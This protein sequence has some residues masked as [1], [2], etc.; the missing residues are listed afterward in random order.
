MRRSE[1]EQQRFE[2]IE[3]LEKVPISAAKQNPLYRKAKLLLTNKWMR[4]PAIHR[5]GLL[6]AA[7][8]LISIA[9]NNPF[10]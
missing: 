9:D 2:L 6:K 3:H 10:S 4:T 7:L 1:L 5:V 8:W